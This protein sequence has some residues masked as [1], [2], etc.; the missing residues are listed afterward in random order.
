MSK[1]TCCF[2]HFG[3]FTVYISL[4]TCKCVNNLLNSSVYKLSIQLKII[5]NYNIHK[6]YYQNCMTPQLPHPFLQTKLPPCVRC[7]QPVPVI[8]ANAFAAL[9][10]P[11]V[12]AE[13]G[14]LLDH[15][16]IHCG[17][18]NSIWRHK[19]TQNHQPS[20]PVITLSITQ[21]RLSHIAFHPQSKENIS[22]INRC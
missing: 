15:P 5:L 3:Y 13:V 20:S 4:S 12:R 2:I 1:Q 6:L 14:D 22:S 16:F 21:P 17:R 19:P 10:F 11:G 7:G 18:R 9:R 8:G